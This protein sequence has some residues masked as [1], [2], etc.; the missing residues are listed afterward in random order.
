[1]QKKKKKKMSEDVFCLLANE[2][3]EDSNGIEWS[4]K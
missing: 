2:M 4:E 1:M 3:M